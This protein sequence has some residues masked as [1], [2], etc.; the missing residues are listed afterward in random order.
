M[1]AIVVV[2][3]ITAVGILIAPYIWAIGSVLA[4]RKETLAQGG[5]RGELCH[6][7]AHDSKI[8]K[9]L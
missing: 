4:H 6:A 9:G 5:K 7:E 1:T 2:A 3:T 8:A